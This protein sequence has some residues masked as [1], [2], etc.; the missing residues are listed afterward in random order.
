MLILQRNSV[1][2]ADREKYRTRSPLDIEN[3]SKRRKDEKLQV[4]IELFSVLALYTCSI[5]DHRVDG[6][7]HN[8]LLSSH[9]SCCCL[10]THQ[11]LNSVVYPL[12]LSNSANTLPQN[13]AKQNL[14]C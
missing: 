7:C 3:D 4:S 8:R 6:D 9:L 14:N 2:P 1:S 11:K 12:L 10:S 13:H 5:I